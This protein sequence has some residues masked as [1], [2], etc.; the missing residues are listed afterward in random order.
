MEK[1]LIMSPAPHIYAKRNTTSIMRDM[2]IA[3]LPAYC[4]AVYVYGESAFW[5]TIVCVVSCVGFE[6]VMQ[7]LLSR[8]ISVGDLSA[9]VTG[10]ILS[11]TLPANLPLWMAVIGSFTA[12]V[13]VK[14]LFGGLG[15]NFVNPALTASLVLRISFPVEMDAWPV[16]DKMIS[17]IREFAG[18]EATTGPQLLELFNRGRVPTGIWTLSSAFQSGPMGTVL[19]L[20]LLAGALYLV[21]RRVIDPVIPGCCLVTMAVLTKLMGFS[22]SFHIFAGTAILVAFFMATDYTTSPYT[23]SGRIIYGVGLGILTMMIRIYGTQTDGALFA[24]LAMNI[25][26]P[27][28]DRITLGRAAK[29]KR[30]ETND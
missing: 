9:A 8:R 19:S 2:L 20:A 3:L 15:Q 17:A 29:R 13:I 28:I 25:L 12:I 21:L 5:L 10:V 14:Q 16:N 30:E 18:S 26:C 22:I 27:Q 6:A 4:A 7:K 11:F 1:E 24:L 23:R